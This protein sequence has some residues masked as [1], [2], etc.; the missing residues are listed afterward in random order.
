MESCGGLVL[1][2][3]SSLAA[4]GGKLSYIEGWKAIDLA[5][6]VFGFNGWSSTIVRM[7]V[8]FVRCQ[9]ETTSVF[10]LLTPLL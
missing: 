1:A 8:D 2:L 5:N 3:T 4:T 6:E 10:S 7:D 9:C